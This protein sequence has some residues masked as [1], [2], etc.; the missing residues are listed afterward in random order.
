M[1][2]RWQVRAR[3]PPSSIETARE[4]HFVSVARA[5]LASHHAVEKRA[6]ARPRTPPGRTRS[7]GPLGHPPRVP[8]RIALWTDWLA[9]GWSARVQ[10]GGTRSY[11]VPARPP[12]TPIQS[13]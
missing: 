2:R 12:P 4:S 5:T 10:T 3:V 9:Q 13:E 8:T 11:E 6:D 1:S 7:R